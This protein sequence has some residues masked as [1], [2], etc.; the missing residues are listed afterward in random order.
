MLTTRLRCERCAHSCQNVTKRIKNI[1]L[2]LCFDT[3]SRLREVCKF[4]SNSV[5]KNACQNMF[6]NTC[7]SN[8][9]KKLKRPKTKG[10]ACRK[11]S[12]SI[13]TCQKVSKSMPTSVSGPTRGLKKLPK[14]LQTQT[15]RVKNG[16]NV[17]KSVKKYVKCKKT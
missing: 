9:V 7:V 14:T 2:T 4:V 17:S 16:S 6:R 3:C 12:K 11:V 15:K 8:S 5:K 13:K 1:F 10:F